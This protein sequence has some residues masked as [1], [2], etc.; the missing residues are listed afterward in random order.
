[1]G[2]P[3]IVAHRA[4]QRLDSV[5]SVAQRHCRVGEP[6]VPGSGPLYSP[7][8]LGISSGRADRLPSLRSASAVSPPPPKQDH[9][10][11]LGRDRC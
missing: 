3:E 6:A 9:P 7:D 1:M 4:A 2:R 11:P 5:A 8:R 10:N